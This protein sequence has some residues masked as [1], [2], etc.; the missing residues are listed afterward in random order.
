[1]IKVEEPSKVKESEEKITVR[2][3]NAGSVVSR[4]YFTDR[5]LRRKKHKFYIPYLK[6]VKPEDIKESE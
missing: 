3:K 1:M 2:I 4:G 6:D 5:Q